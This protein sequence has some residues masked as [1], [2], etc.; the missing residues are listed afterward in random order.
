MQCRTT[1][2]LVEEFVQFY[3]PNAAELF[4]DEASVG[5]SVWLEVV[6]MGKFH[7]SM[8]FQRMYTQNQNSMGFH[9]VKHLIATN[10]TSSVKPT[11]SQLKFIRVQRFR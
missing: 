2:I 6:S 5:K 9:N 4:V 7:F 8:L 1:R 10:I 11:S 3:S